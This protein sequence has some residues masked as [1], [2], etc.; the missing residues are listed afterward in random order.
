MDAKYLVVAPVHLYE[1]DIVHLSVEYVHFIHSLQTNGVDL[2]VFDYTRMGRKYGDQIANELLRTAFRAHKYSM[3]IYFPLA[4]H[5]I[6]EETWKSR[7]RIPTVMWVFNDDWRFET[8]Y[9]SMCWLFDAVVTDS[10]EG[11]ARYEEIAFEDV[12]YCPRAICP[13]WFSVAG[14]KLYS[15]MFSGTGHGNRP[16]L[17]N[18]ATGG[19]DQAFV[20]GINGL[21]LKWVEYTAHMSA[22]KTVISPS[23]ASHGDGHQFKF[24]DFEAAASGA[25]PISDNP[26]ISDMFEP[27]VECETFTDQNDLREKIEMLV[28]NEELR[29]QIAIAARARVIREHQYIHRF[30][31]VVPKLKEM[32]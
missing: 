22:A 27:G 16:S 7:P 14:N 2:D 24:R 13:S 25:V 3:I 17:I 29:S 8:D 11:P 9:S 4:G 15:T 23:K 20:A 10:P 18:N 26:R 5:E 30:Q 28:D 31:E 32:V 19:L 21:Y 1:G 6:T 12:V